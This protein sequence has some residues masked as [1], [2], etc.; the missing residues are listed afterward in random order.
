MEPNLG[1]ERLSNILAKCIEAAKDAHRKC[2]SGVDG[3]IRDN[4]SY[5]IGALETELEN[6]RPDL[7]EI[8]PKTN[9]PFYRRIFK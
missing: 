6:V 2:S 9:E 3:L 5:I 4:L 1:D 8:D 7:M